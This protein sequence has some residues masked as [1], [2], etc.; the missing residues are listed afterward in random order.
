MKK[1]LIALVIAGVAML[2]GTSKTNAQMASN[3]NTLEY[4]RNL[5]NEQDNISRKALKNFANTHRSI[6]DE[7]WLQAK[8]GCIVRFINEGINTNISYDRKGNWFGSVKSYGEEKLP[9]DIRHI[10]KSDYYD[11][12]ILSIQE[13]ETIDSKGVPT[14]IINMQ[15][16]T[17]IKIVRIHEGEMNVWKEYNRAK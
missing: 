1:N 14:Y 5:I 7:K 2:A 15:S 3:G 11:Y 8:D 6:K 12:M 16:N 17:E 10:V 13:I 4:Q 9:R